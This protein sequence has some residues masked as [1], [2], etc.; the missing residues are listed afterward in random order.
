MSILIGI[1]LNQQIALGSMD[2]LTVL[3]LPNQEHGISFHL[4]ISFSNSF[5]NFL[6]FSEQRS[7]TSLVK[8][9]PRYFILFDETLN[10]IFFLLSLSDNSLLLQRKADFCI[11]ILYPVT[12][13]NSLINSNSFLVQTLGFSIQSIISSAKSDNFTYFFSIQMAFS[14]LI[15]VA[16]TF[17][18]MLNRSGK[19]GHSYLILDFSRKAESFSPLNMMLAVGFS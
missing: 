17:N 7:F 13:L 19:S 4:F 16:M 15:A 2:I 5:I 1:A 12:L 8:F 11:L 10:E 3:I 14:C 18:T 9:I 6:Q